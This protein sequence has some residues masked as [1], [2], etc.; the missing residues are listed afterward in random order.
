MADRAAK[1][2]SFF[3]LTLLCAAPSLAQAP[4]GKAPNQWRPLFNGKNLDGWEHVGPGRFVIENGLLR[5]EGGMGLLWYTREKLGNCVLRVV[6]KTSNEWS[7]SGMYVRIDEKPTDP[8]YAVHHGFEVQIYDNG[9][10]DGRS[11]SVFSFARAQADPSKPREWNTLE[12]VLRGKRITTFINGTTVADYDS[13]ELNRQATDR[14]GQANPARNPRAESGYI[15]LQN[16]DDH[17]PVYFKE[18]SV[19]PLSAAP[20]N[21]VADR[22]HLDRLSAHEQSIVDGAGEPSDVLCREHII[23]VWPKDLRPVWYAESRVNSPAKMADWL[24]KAYFLSMF[25]TRFDPSGHYRERNHESS[26]LVFIHNGQ[27]DFVFGGKRPFIGLRDLKGPR[28]GSDDWFGWLI[29]EMSHD[30][31]HEH[32]AFSRVR[33]PW[34]EAMCDYMRYSVL[35][36]MGMRQAAARNEK[37]LRKAPPDDAYRGGAWMF[38]SLQRARRFDGPQALWDYLWDR[39][40]VATFGRPP[41]LK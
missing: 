25:W 8:L 16:Y 29:H 2:V 1:V 13:S 26:R 12:V 37:V 9:P 33:Q 3:L 39:D 30:F 31:W 22:H 23:L 27:G 41:W 21:V 7:N 11:G 4:K 14:T 28:P 34:G 20:S 40:F 15:G 6:Y 10:G 36:Y 24:E 35:L 18:V 32:S 19:G 17:A 38:L 5:T